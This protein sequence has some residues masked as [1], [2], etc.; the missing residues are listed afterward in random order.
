MNEILHSQKT[1][2][3]IAVS[4]KSTFFAYQSGPAGTPAAKWTRR[5]RHPPTLFQIP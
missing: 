1:V 2:K 5:R 3:G 4:I